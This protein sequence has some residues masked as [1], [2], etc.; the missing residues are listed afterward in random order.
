MSTVLQFIKRS[1]TFSLL[2]LAIIVRIIKDKPHCLIATTLQWF[3][4]KGGESLCLT[5]EC[6]VGCQF[7]FCH[8]TLSPNML[9]TYHNPF[10]VC[11]KTYADC[12]PISPICLCIT[13]SCYE[14]H[15]SNRLFLISYSLLYLLV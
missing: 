12:K 13:L 8:I 1:G 9:I 3:K 14:R 4:D 7:P 2:A 11:R 15:N 6:Y 10:Q 5:L